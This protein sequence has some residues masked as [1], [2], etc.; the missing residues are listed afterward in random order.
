MS[1]FVN[2]MYTRYIVPFV[3]YVMG[4]AF[5]INECWGI[6]FSFFLLRVNRLCCYFHGNHHLEEILMLE[7][8]TRSQLLTLIDKYSEVLVTVSLTEHSNTN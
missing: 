4:V 2:F 3:V 8:M 5:L 6:F 7:N 1:H